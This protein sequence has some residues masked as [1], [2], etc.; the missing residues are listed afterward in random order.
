MALVIKNGRIVSSQYDFIGDLAIVDG[1][2]SSLATAGTL[3]GEQE[4]DATGKLVL[5]GVI[6]V[7]THFDLPIMDSSTADDFE[8]GSMAG[9][10]GGV[11]SFIDFVTPRKGKALFD[12]LEIRRAQA[13]PN[14]YTDYSLHMGIVDFNNDSFNAIKDV[15]EYGI[16]SFKIFTAY[17]AEGW[18]AGD[19]DM[20]RVLEETK[21]Y[22]GL[23]GV[24]AENQSIID[25][26]TADLLAEGK[27]SYKWHAESRPHHSEVEAIRRVLYLTELSGGRLHIFHLTTG[28]GARLLGEAVGRGVNVTA[29]TCP[30]YLVLDDRRFK[31]D[32]GWLYPLCPPLRN[33][34]DSEVLWR[35]T[36]LGFIK[37]IAT[38]HC[39]FTI[40]QKERFKDDF[41]K[42]PRGLPGCETLLPIVYTEGVR[43]GRITLSEMTSLLS[44]SPAKSFGMAPAKGSLAPG[45]DADIVIIDPEVKKTV[46][47]E[48]L[49][50]KADY[51]PYAGMELYGFP[52]YTISRGEVIYEEGRGFTGK[53]GR[54]KFIKRKL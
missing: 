46:S 50:M 34:F 9:A 24:H 35:A 13:D 15:I 53:K 8:S 39:S 14:V 16:P 18:M 30:Q 10:A 3:A 33:A 19:G 43:K 48:T 47:T 54:G 49:H 29:E 51:S 23:M 20:L 45:A 2:I 26:A 21:K 25:T 31:R 41:T 42:I 28:E 27:R 1:K 6:D 12:E 5:P 36:K 44:T 38:D 17:A 22:G 7:H 11:T 37:N 40:A 32:N 52:T 4:I